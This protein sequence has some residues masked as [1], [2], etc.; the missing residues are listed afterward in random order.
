MSPCCCAAPLDQFIDKWD[1]ITN[2][3]RGLDECGVDGLDGYNMKERNS[4]WG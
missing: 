3:V 1:W 2:E 4:V